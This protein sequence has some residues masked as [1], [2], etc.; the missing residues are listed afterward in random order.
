MY[1]VAAFTHDGHPFG[2]TKV[3]DRDEAERTA[4]RYMANSKIGRVSVRKVLPAMAT[5]NGR[6]R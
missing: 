1:V 3:Q 6:F 4:T 2:S 5:G